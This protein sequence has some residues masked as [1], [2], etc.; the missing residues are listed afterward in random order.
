MSY[1]RLSIS[2]IFCGSRCTALRGYRLCKI[3]SDFSIKDQEIFWSGVTSMALDAQE[4]TEIRAKTE[5]D[6]T[7]GDAEEAHAR[8]SRASG[9]VARESNQLWGARDSD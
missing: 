8:N 1:P 6:T 4:A 2:T 7:A 5:H 3:Q 9:S